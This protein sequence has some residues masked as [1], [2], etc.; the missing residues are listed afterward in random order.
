[1]KKTIW[2]LTLATVVLFAGVAVAY[3]NTSSIGYDN[4]NIV[5]FNKEQI[6]VFDYNIEYEKVKDK[7]EKFEK[8][9]PQEYITI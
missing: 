5:S 8:S 4:A 7:I 9:L 2:I 1:M 6:K 3:Y